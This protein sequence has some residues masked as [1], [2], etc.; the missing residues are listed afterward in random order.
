MNRCMD[1]SHY[2]L[3]NMF[4]GA[5]SLDIVNNEQQG[6]LIFALFI[7]CHFAFVLL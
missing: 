4:G 5:P 7:P 6:L 2:I 1:H 3:T